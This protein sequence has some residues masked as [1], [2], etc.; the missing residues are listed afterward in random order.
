[1]NSNEYKIVVNL[2][3]PDGNEEFVIWEP[4]MYADMIDRR[5]DFH[6]LFYNT[7]DAI[8]TPPLEVHIF[9]YHNP[10]I[11]NISQNTGSNSVIRQLLVGRRICHIK[12]I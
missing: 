11:T 10:T 5:I 3:F 7:P 1:M 4:L 9:L 12:S 6:K 8:K 2:L